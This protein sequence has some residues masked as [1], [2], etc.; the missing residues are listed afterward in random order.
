MRKMTNTEKN[1]VKM[2][3]RQQKLDSGLI[4]E[5]FPEVSNII[6]N[7]KNLHGKKN[8]ITISRDFRFWPDSS[9]YFTLEC[10]IKGCMNGGFDLTKA[11]TT[12]IKNQKDSVEGELCCKGDN[13]SSDHSR[14]YYKISILYNKS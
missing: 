6:I 4:S 9:A 2:E 14:I 10:L 12:M 8:P 5:H 11:I 1:V 13:L 3:K 7:V